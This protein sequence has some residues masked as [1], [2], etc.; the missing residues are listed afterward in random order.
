MKTGFSLGQ[1]KELDGIRG[2]AILIVMAF[3]FG[4]PYCDGGWLG[5]DLFF[6]LSGFLITSLLIKEWNKTQKINLLHFYARRALRLLPALFL[7]LIVLNVLDYY[8][9]YPVDPTSSLKRSSFYS[10]FYFA[11][12]ARAIGIPMGPLEHTWSLSIEEQYY[13]MWP[14]IV[15]LFLKGGKLNGLLK[16]L[17]VVLISMMLLKVF[18]FYQDIPLRHLYNGL[19]A[20][21]DE[22]I[23]G[24]GLAIILSYKPTDVIQ[25]FGQK[26]W[27]I[28]IGGTLVF[29]YL[30]HAI[31]WT[32][33]FVYVGGL[34]VAAFTSALIVFGAL[35]GPPFFKKVL[36]IPFLAFLGKISY[37]LY[38]FHWPI[39]IYVNDGLKI[40]YLPLAILIKFVLTIAI[41]YI[42]FNFMEKKFLSLKHKFP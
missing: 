17:F 15:S 30:T 29:A 3:H 22:L 35:V 20:R 23:F 26:I 10:L 4:I 19:Y 16:T 1:I 34:T 12:W 14:F 28:I 31:S 38:L 21:L 9:L 11:N 33:P 2:I 5:V 41:S 25:R 42:S 37:G 24:S 27:I 40:H 32:D 6:T 39:N 13:I 7:L 36:R 8:H 18:L